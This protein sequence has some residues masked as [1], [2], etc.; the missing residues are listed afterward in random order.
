MSERCG[1]CKHWRIDE[2]NYST[3]ANDIVE[4]I[5]PDTF[6]PMAM[7]FEVKQCSH[8]K[9]LFCERPV[10]TPGFAVADGSTYMAGLF[11]TADFGCVMH[12]PKVESPA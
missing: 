10:E 3:Q 4:P 2:K 7:P 6:Q 5:D 8:P 1:T 11:T 12:E 9:L